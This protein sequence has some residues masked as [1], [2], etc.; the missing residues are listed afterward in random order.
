MSL[1]ELA[2]SEVVLTIVASA[3]IFLGNSRATRLPPMTTIYDPS[4]Y[5]FRNAV[6]SLM[7]RVR[8][9]LFD[10][11]EVELAPYGIKAA[12]YLVLVALA[13]EAAVT[14]SAVCSVMAHDPGAMT[15]KIDALEHKG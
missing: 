9:A 1:R 8:S 6:P 11:V 14:A 7:A 4:T 10:A 3:D 15:R 5:D 12:E 2:R 13:N